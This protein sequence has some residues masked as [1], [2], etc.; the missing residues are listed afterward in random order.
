MLSGGG[1]DSASAGCLVS[2]A[3]ALLALIGML[4]AGFTVVLMLELLCD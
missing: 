3:L 1:T 2:L 4:A